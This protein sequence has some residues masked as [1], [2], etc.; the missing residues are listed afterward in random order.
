M[1]LHRKGALTNAEVDD[2]FAKAIAAQMRVRSE[3]NVAAA[4]L[5]MHIED[6]M[7]SSGR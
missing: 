2:V 4:R 5:L 1:V 7:K 3:T 6:A